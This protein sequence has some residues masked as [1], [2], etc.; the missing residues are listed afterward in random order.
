MTIVFAFF[1]GLFPLVFSEF[2]LQ[3]YTDE[4]GDYLA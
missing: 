3:A 1:P 4:D 2:L